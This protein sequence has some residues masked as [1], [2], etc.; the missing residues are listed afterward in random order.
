MELLGVCRCLQPIVP[1]C[2]GRLVVLHVDAMNLLGIVNRGSR[3]S[4]ST[5]WRGSSYGFAYAAETSVWWNGCRGMRMLSWMLSLRCSSRRTICS[6]D[7]EF[8]IVFTDKARID[9]E[10][11]TVLTSYLAN[12][13][14]LYNII[15]KQITRIAKRVR[16]YNSHT[17]PC[18]KFTH[19]H[20]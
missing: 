16:N 4:P 10:F 5:I 12:P 9:L 14:P 3:G 11:I 20:I 17:I 2:A 8:K 6:H 7:Q 1:R 15:I 19:A 18:K 13:T